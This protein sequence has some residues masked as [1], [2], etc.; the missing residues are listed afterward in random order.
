MC[1]QVK[2]PKVGCVFPMVWS[3]FL[4]G[5]LKDDGHQGVASHFTRSLVLRRSPFHHVKIK[6]FFSQYLPQLT[7]RILQNPLTG[8]N[9]NQ[10]VCAPKV[11]VGELSFNGD[12][13]LILSCNVKDLIIERRVSTKLNF[14]VT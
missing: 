11:V 12:F 8:V 5:Q 9:G 2:P 13:V 14:C 3:E 1:F 4:V 7:P 10:K 6:T